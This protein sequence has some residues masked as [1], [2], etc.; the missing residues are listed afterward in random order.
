MDIKLKLNK[1]QKSTNNFNDNELSIFISGKDNNYVLVNT[2]RRICVSSIP[3]YAFHENDM[4]FDINTSIWN[5]DMLKDRFRNLP[6][7]NI[8]NDETT[9]EKFEDLEVKK[10]RIVD[11]AN[12]LTMFV[13]IKNNRDVIFNVT[14][15]EAIFY[16]K[17]KQ[18]NSPYKKPLLLIKLKKGQELKCT[19]ISSLNIGKNDGIYNAAMAYHYNENENANNKYELVLNS[20]R[21][22]D[23]LEILKR[24]CKILLN[25][26]FKLEKLIIVNLEKEDNSEILNRG[27]LK[28]VDEN[29]TFGNLISYYL[30]ENKHMEF[31]GAQVPFLYLNEILIRYRTDGK[32]I[33][34]IIKKTFNQIREIYNHILKELESLK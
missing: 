7:F 33:K 1:H 2:L 23:E 5:N 32:D 20:N 28:I 6:I 13:N 9:I 25:K 21:Q 15:N 10:D 30:Q 16:H 11:N 4:I 22:I 12:N 31:S 18:I 14:T 27:L 29:A 17:G 3:I 24:S 34:D 19:C 8:D 26:T